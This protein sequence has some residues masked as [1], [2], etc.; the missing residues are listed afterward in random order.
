GDHMDRF[1]GSSGSPGTSRSNDKSM[2]EARE[3]RAALQGV[4]R[5]CGNSKQAAPASTAL[6]GSRIQASGF[7]GGL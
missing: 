2:A 6:S 7:A 1:Q 3:K 5:C 4:S